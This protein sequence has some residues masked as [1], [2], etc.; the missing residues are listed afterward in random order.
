MER[1]RLIAKWFIQWSCIGWQYRR[2]F[3]A[4]ACGLRKGFRLPTAPQRYT[5]LLAFQAAYSTPTPKLAH[6]LQHS[7]IS[8]TQNESPP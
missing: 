7:S 2:T 4:F 6:H 3:D 5:N 8:S 1:R